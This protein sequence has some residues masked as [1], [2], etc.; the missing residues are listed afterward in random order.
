VTKQLIDAAPCPGAHSEVLEELGA[1]AGRLPSKGSDLPPKRCY[2]RVGWRRGA[3]LA[4]SV[5]PHEHSFPSGRSASRAEIVR[6]LGTGSDPGVS[7]ALRANPRSGARAAAFPE[8][9]RK[10]PQVQGFSV[11][12]L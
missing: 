5:V 2:V 6:P 10:S 7:S 8:L 12:G 11:A 3:G 4:V 1:L 9:N